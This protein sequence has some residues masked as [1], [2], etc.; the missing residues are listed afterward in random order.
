M[1]AGKGLQSRL[2]CR[3]SLEN[4]LLD[5]VDLVAVQRCGGR[6]RHYGADAL[7]SLKKYAVKGVF[8]DNDSGCGDHVGIACK[9]QTSCLC[10]IIVTT[11]VIAAYLEKRQDLFVETYVRFRKH[12]LRGRS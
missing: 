1:K 2:V 11:G 4:P 5:A 3:R 6:R 10:A 9:A 8:R 7:Y 12:D